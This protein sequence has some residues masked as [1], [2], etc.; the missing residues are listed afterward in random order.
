MAGTVERGSKF[1]KG[2]RAVQP[3]SEDQTVQKASD[4]LGREVGLSI[5]PDTLC[6]RHSSGP[7]P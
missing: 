5:H 2:R 1:W 7:W 4:A 6:P 3:P